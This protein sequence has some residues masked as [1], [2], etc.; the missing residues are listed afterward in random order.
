MRRSPDPPRQTKELQDSIDLERVRQMA[1][2]MPIDRW[3]ALVQENGPAR[4]A[5]QLGISKKAAK[6]VK[7]KGALRF[8]EALI[9]QT[10][11]K[12]SSKP[13]EGEEDFALQPL[14]RMRELSDC[15]GVQKDL[16]E[17]ATFFSQLRRAGRDVALSKLEIPNWRPNLFLMEEFVEFL[18]MAADLAAIMRATKDDPQRF[19]QSDFLAVW[20][21]RLCANRNGVILPRSDDVYYGVQA[22][23]KYLENHLQ[24]LDSYAGGRVLIPIEYFGDKSSPDPLVIEALL[25][26]IR[27]HDNLKKAAAEALPVQ[28]EF[29]QLLNRPEAAAKQVFLKGR[30]P[31]LEGPRWR[32]A[33]AH[34]CREAALTWVFAKDLPGMDGTDFCERLRPVI[35]ENQNLFRL[36]L[37]D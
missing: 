14:K 7:K 11:T 32:D 22:L 8:R 31:L 19:L 28:I 21:S 6:R 24:L 5:K 13:E 30:I 15:G 1:A 16:N 36:R 10:D 17:L 9:D 12:R 25:R 34:R 20:I 4:L 35:R 26:T 29:N 23:R 27:S 33:S 3:L 18:T 2:T 37:P